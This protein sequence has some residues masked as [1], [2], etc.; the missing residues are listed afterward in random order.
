MPSSVPQ[1]LA[2]MLRN[3]RTYIG[4]SPTPPYS[5]EKNGP[6]RKIRTSNFLYVK[7]VLWPVELCEDKKN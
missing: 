6:H 5:S 4:Y 7:E 2:K 1:A 3:P